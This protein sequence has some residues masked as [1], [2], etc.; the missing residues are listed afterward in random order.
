MVIY[1]SVSP[2]STQLVLYMINTSSDS[3][4]YC[5]FSVLFSISDVSISLQ[6][7]QCYRQ[8]VL[9]IV[10]SEL[11]TYLTLSFRRLPGDDIWLICNHIETG[12]CL[13][14]QASRVVDLGTSG[15]DVSRPERSCDATRTSPK[16]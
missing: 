16:Q 13:I 12:R 11:S 10:R 2:C 8:N 6:F 7:N 14:L 4:D 5:L 15:Y 1:R 3:C 9:C